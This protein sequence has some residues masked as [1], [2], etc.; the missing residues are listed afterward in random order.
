MKARFVLTWKQDDNGKD[1]A[2]ARLVIQGY[3]DPDALAGKLESSSPTGTRLARLVLLLEASVRHWNLESADVKTA[4][5]QSAPK[6]L[7][8]IHI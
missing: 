7:S 8:L 3:N 4:F 1:V 2:K 5:L 6:D